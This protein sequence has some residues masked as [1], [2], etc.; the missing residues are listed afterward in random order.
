YKT[1]PII[2]SELEELTRRQEDDPY[3][4][5]QIYSH[6]RFK[7]LSRRTNK[8]FQIATIQRWDYF[9]D[10]IIE[11]DDKQYIKFTRFHFPI[12]NQNTYFRSTFLLLANGRLTPVPEDSV[13]GHP[14]NSNH[15][16][17]TRSMQISPYFALE[18]DCSRHGVSASNGERL[19]FYPHM[20]DAIRL[21]PI[22]FGKQRKPDPNRILSWE[23]AQW[24]DDSCTYLM[25][26]VRTIVT[27]CGKRVR[28]KDIMSRFPAETH[29]QP[30]W[31]GYPMRLCDGTVRFGRKCFS[32]LIDID[33]RQYKSIFSRRP[34]YPASKLRVYCATPTSLDSFE[35][36]GNRHRPLGASHQAHLACG[37]IDST[38]RQT[39]SFIKTLPDTP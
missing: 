19:F 38:F 31:G 35:I 22:L 34:N 17:L 27:V 29:F 37:E 33:A 15:G 24:S 30:Y 26:E 2:G 18:V 20:G 1:R 5:S 16:D 10:V 25:S 12:S 23:Y 28:K 3:F 9:G 39:P 7:Y 13:C 8:W 11:M 6:E 21:D 14:I 32:N 36:I 4:S